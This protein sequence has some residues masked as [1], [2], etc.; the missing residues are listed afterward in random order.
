MALMAARRS[1]GSS[2][3]HSFRSN[4]NH[5]P[6]DRDLEHVL[7]SSRNLASLGRSSSPRCHRAA[8]SIVNM[9]PIP[10]PAWMMTNGQI[11]GRNSGICGTAPLASVSA[12][13]DNRSFRIRRLA[14]TP[15]RLLLRCDAGLKHRILQSLKSRSCTERERT[16]TLRDYLRNSTRDIL[17]QVVQHLPPPSA[18]RAP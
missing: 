1:I 8:D 6:C 11:D 5:R 17:Q 7:G 12:S 4:R 3:E 2:S 18:T 14:E 16:S 15:K 13:A 10:V 9:R